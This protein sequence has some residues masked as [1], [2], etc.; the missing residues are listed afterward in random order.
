[1]NLSA[2]KNIACAFLGMSFLLASCSKDDN[3][4]VEPLK[5]KTYTG[6]DL[7]LIYNGNPMPNKSV[8]LTQNGDKATARLFSEFDLSQLSA[9]GLSGKIPAPG[10]LPG[11]VETELNLNMIAS[12]K[13]WR[14]SGS[15][16]TTY[17]TFDYEGSANSD[18]LALDLK[19]V[20]L[21]TGGITPVVWQPAPIKK[22]NGA[23]TSLPVYLDWEYDP[24][25]DVDINFTPLLDILA[26]APVIP[27]YNNTAYM[28]VSEALVLMIKTVAFKDDGNIIISYVSNIGGAAGLAQTNPNCF[29]YLPVSQNEVK[30]FINPTS[31]FGMA[32]MANSTGMP[33]DEVKIIGNGLYSNGDATNDPGALGELLKS[34]LGQKIAKAMLSALLPKLAEGL[35]VSFSTSATG[36]DLYIDTPMIAEIINDVILP[37]LKDDAAI[38]AVGEYLASI[39]EIAP[40]LPDLQK[41]MQVLPQALERTTTFRVGV[42]LIP[43]TQSSK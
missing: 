43:Y 6:S 40:L 35:P 17:C 38:K 31:V 37:L 28:S 36:L 21:K 19:N 41:A 34:E 4:P 26:T 16:E 9:F 7:T 18:K 39:P 42:S 33:A 8:T 11:S 32:L 14:F 12:N 20:K 27:V 1:M 2:M 30:L 10:V 15:G 24:L 25:P 3:K 5:E 29:M 22:E 13:D 23:Y